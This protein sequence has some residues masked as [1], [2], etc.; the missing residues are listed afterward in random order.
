MRPAG[1]LP[2]ALL[3]VSILVTAV[4]VL[5]V[6][7]SGPEET[8]PASPDARL[9][10]PVESFEAEGPEMPAL[11][12]VPYRKL[13]TEAGA[14]AGEKPIGGPAGS[15]DERV[16]GLA[17]D[18]GGVP[19]ARVPIEVLALPAG[20]R[21]DLRQGSAVTGPDGRFRIGLKGRFRIPGGFRLR[22]GTGLCGGRSPGSRVLASPRV[23]LD[24]GDLSRCADLG[25]VMFTA[26]PC[27]VSGQVVDERGIPVPG[28][29]ICLGGAGLVVPGTEE[30][31]ADAFIEGKGLVASRWQGLDPVSDDRG[32]FEVWGAA[33]GSECT[34]RSEAIVAVGSSGLPVIGGQV[35]F[36]PGT[37]DLVVKIRRTGGVRGRLLL[38]RAL[39]EE[40]P[41]EL[42]MLAVRVASENGDGYASARIQGDGSFSALGLTPGM[43]RLEVL[44]RGAA[45]PAVVVPGIEVSG[46]AVVEPPRIQAVDLREHL[47][48]AS[49]EVC[50]D[51]GSEVPGAKVKFLDNPE[52]APMRAE[53]FSADGRFE[54]WCARLPVRAEVGGWGHYPRIVGIAETHGRVVLH[55]G[56]RVNFRLVADLPRL[57]PSLF[58]C[59]QVRL[60]PLDKGERDSPTPEGLDFPLD[61]ERAAQVHVA[62]TGMYSASL[63]FQE[64]FF[65]GCTAEA[66]YEIERSICIA[67]EDDRTVTLVLD[68]SQVADLR[69]RLVD[70]P[71]AR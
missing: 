36:T 39:L 14:E 62:G 1:R 58:S 22:L 65:G 60:R 28:I 70:S 4:A 64:I 56:I 19:L 49:I 10:P 6:L 44:V 24:A 13:E 54:V 23:V 5:M 32:R 41:S 66:I 59:F 67:P 9:A 45:A 26:L 34:L 30:S 18:A 40:L 7:A 8:G 55:R 27:L 3:A 42:P 48:R 17:V 15:E 61:S 68:P 35:R 51:D 47:D 20:D 25:T 21:V 63:R 53:E 38:P 29:L 37:Q 31:W 57:E 43:H 69:R 46:G 2:V 71:S 52:G 16:A 11:R 50:T 33:E 12:A